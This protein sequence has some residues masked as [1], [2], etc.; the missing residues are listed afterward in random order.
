VDAQAEP[1]RD[2]IALV[3]AAHFVCLP[4]VACIQAERL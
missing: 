2:A 4:D 1:Q 3:L